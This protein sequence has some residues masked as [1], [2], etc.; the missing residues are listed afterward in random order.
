MTHNESTNV[1]LLTLFDHLVNFE[2]L[3]LEK[4]DSS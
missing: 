1:C 3:T 4:K 2:K